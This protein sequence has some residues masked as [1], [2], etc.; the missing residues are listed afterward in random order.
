MRTRLDFLLAITL[1]TS[2]P[3]VSALAQGRQP[4]WTAGLNLGP[5]ASS[6]PELQVDRRLF[7]RLAFAAS[8]GY[9]SRVFS[10]GCLVGDPVDLNRQ[11]GGFMK[12]GLKARLF[13]LKRACNQMHVTLHYVGSWYN[14]SG[15]RNV[16]LDWAPRTKVPVS[17][18]G[19]VNGVAASA[20]WDLGLFRALR[21]RFGFQVGRYWRSEHLDAVCHYNQPGLGTAYHIL[22]AQAIIGLAYDFGGRRY[23]ATNED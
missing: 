21:M 1:L 9:T 19:F 15:T 14:E 22:P 12:A 17:A 8:G 4:S 13:C 7:G 20:Y 23:W 6:T 10:A 2:W 18:Q 3:F 11:R 5:L 16:D